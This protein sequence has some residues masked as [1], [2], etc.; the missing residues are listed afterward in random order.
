VNRVDGTNSPTSRSIQ[1]CIIMIDKFKKQWEELGE[2]DP[3]WAVISDPEK[4]NDQWDED[5]FFSIGQDEINGVFYEVSQLGVLIEPGVALDYGCGVGRLS[6]ALA[7]SFKL[8]LGVDFS[9]TMISEAKSANARFENIRFLNNNGVDLADL[10]DKSVDFIYSNMVL[11]H[12]PRH[13]QL[14]LIKEFCRVLRPNGILVFQA[15]SRQRLGTVG[16]ALHFVLGNRFLNLV[17]RVRHGKSRV[18]EMHNL[19]KAVVEIVLQDE[20]MELLKAEINEYAGKAFKSYRYF[21]IK[22]TR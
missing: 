14:S 4:K 22:K 9:E 12:S 15:P 7:K 16:G 13:V 10:S 17:S 18:M 5:E 2:V 1:K 6:R 19:R 20:G 21:S 11:Q 3:Y 8:V